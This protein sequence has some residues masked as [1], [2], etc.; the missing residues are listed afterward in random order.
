MRTRKH[1]IGLHLSDREFTKLD[2]AVKKSGLNY[3]V[4]LRHLIASR[5]PQDRPPPEYFA[6]LKELRAIG[7]NINQ[8]AFIANATGI[9]DAVRF[10]EKYRELTGLILKLIDA[11]EMPKEAR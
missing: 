11:A 2:H 7:R 3:S 1:R 6:V 5:I 4:Y 10:D 9:I 8:M